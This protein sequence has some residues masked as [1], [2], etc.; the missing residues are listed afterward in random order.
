LTLVDV[1]MIGAAG[2]LYLSGRTGDVTAARARI[3][4]VLGAIGGREG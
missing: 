4:K 1:Q 3:E 2:R